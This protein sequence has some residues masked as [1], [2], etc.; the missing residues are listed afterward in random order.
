MAPHT[1]HYSPHSKGKGKDSDAE[2][3]TDEPHPEVG[4]SA[5]AD[6]IQRPKGLINFGQAPFGGLCGLLDVLESANREGHKKPGFKGNL[7]AKFF[8]VRSLLPSI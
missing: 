2:D 6:D 4:E 3:E 7:I 8:A 5:E 1:T